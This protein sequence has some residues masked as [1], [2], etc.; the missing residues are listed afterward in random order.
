MNAKDLQTY[1]K[2]KDQITLSETVYETAYFEGEFKG[3]E[4]G[5][6]QGI[7]QEKLEW[8]LNVFKEGLS[9]ESIARIARIPE[10]EVHDILEKHDLI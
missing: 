1:K 10:N 8:I 6:E 3:I 7:E 9:I 5:I 4:K 2:F